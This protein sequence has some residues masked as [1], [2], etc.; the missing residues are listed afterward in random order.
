MQPA[1]LRCLCLPSR[2]RCLTFV[3]TL[4]LPCHLPRWVSPPY[5]TAQH[6]E[7]VQDVGARTALDFGQQR[8]LG[9][10]VLSFMA[11]TIVI[12]L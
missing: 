2:Q 7:T 9:A 6:W 4:K 11:E 8:P 1:T 3:L 5:D 10:P 12:L